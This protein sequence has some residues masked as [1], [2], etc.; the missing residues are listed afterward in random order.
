MTDSGNP[1]DQSLSVSVWFVRTE[2]VD[3]TNKMFNEA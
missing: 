2:P 1:H 3:E